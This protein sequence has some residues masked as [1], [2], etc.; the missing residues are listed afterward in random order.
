MTSNAL[1]RPL[2]NSGLQ[3]TPDAN[4]LK[5]AD[6]PIAVHSC[7]SQ[8]TQGKIFRFKLHATRASQNVIDVLTWTPITWAT[9]C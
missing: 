7:I 9:M 5:N 6:D 1:K 4:S 2:T 8:F 3:L